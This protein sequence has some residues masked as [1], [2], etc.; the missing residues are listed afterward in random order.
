MKRLFLF[1]GI[2]ISASTIGVAWPFSG[3]SIKPYTTVLIY[4]AISAHPPTDQKQRYFTVTPTQLADHVTYATNFQ[5]PVI[6]LI[7]RDDPETKHY[8]QQFIAPSGLPILFHTYPTYRTFTYD[9]L[10][11]Y[12]PKDPPV[13]GSYPVVVREVSGTAPRGDFKEIL[14]NRYLNVD[15]FSWYVSNNHCATTGLLVGVLVIAFGFLSLRNP[16]ASCALV[17]ATLPWYPLRLVLSGIPFTLPE[18]L[19]LSAIV[20]WAPYYRNL[21][22][23]IRRIET[24]HMLFFLTITAIALTLATRAQTGTSFGYARA[25]FGIPMVWCMGIIGWART[26]QDVFRPTIGYLIGAAYV[27]ILTLARFLTGDYYLHFDGQVRATFFGNPN[28]LA[29]FLAPALILSIGWYQQAR[30][31]LLVV[32]IVLGALV[33]YL[34]LSKGAMLGV[35]AAA[36]YLVFAPRI[37]RIKQWIPVLIVSFLGITIGVQ[38]LFAARSSFMLQASSIGSRIAV[39]QTSMIML[40]KSP[41]FGIGLANFRDEFKKLV[42]SASPEQDTAFAHNTFLDM[43]LQLGILGLFVF[44]VWILGAFHIPADQKVQEVAFVFQAAL[45][46]K[47]VHG[48]VDSVFFKNDFSVVTIYLIGAL[49]YSMGNDTNIRLPFLWR[50]DGCLKKLD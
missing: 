31:F 9:I 13:N 32:F 29:A 4:H 45:L 30:Q 36:L 46:A 3:A 50:S 8:V 49:W 27:C 41:I 21:I 6:F 16:V 48:L 25:F 22:R 43:W 11:P 14:P 12:L 44:F 7:R 1:A 5:Y 19:M 20:M 33:F 47:L 23:K 17:L 40:E 39:Y 34:T 28:H 37:H 18:L 26:P 42:S 24:V 15:C 35:G 38:L 10:A 2:V